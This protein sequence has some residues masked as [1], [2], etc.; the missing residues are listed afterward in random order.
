VGIRS[1]AHVL[2]SFRSPQE[3]ALTTVGILMTGMATMARKGLAR[4]R[5]PV[6][7]T[8]AQSEDTAWS[9]GCR[10]AQSFKGY[11]NKIIPLDGLA[12]YFGSNYGAEAQFVRKSL[13]RT[14]SHEKNERT[15][16]S[17]SRT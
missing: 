16:V 7:M 17:S 6:G 3:F 15:P 9:A 11:A 12:S 4:S 2:L 8:I 5:L 14:T 13:K 10:R 1:A